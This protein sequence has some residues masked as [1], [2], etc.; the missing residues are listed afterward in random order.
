MPAHDHD[1][2]KANYTELDGPPR[3]AAA[4]AGS[5]KTGKTGGLPDGSTKAHENMPPYLVSVFIKK[6]Q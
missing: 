6:I 1:T 5:G 4:V 2:D 3:Y